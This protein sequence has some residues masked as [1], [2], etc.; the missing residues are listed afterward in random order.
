MIGIGRGIASIA[1]LLFGTAVF[2]QLN[3]Y[4]YVVVPTHFEDYKKSNQYQT[5]TV[6]KYLFSQE[7][8][9]VVYDTQ[10][11]KELRVEPCL[12]AYVR[13]FDTSGMFMTRV[14]L[15]LVDCEGNLILETE[16]G[17]SKSKD[18]AQAYKEALM[19]A[20][21]SIQGMEYQ[22]TPMAKTESIQN[23]EEIAPA[24]AQ[25]AVNEPIITSEGPEETQISEPIVSESDTFTPETKPALDYL[26]AQPTDN[27]YQLV[28]SVPS[29]RMLLIKTSKP[30]TFLA[31]INGQNAGTVFKSEGVWVREY[32]NGAELIQEVLNIKF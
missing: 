20:F 31:L 6:I 23:P 12:G 29:I 2:G 11:P 27:G 15:E 10:Q 18:Y 28:D 16:E 14:K 25:Q 30:D 3:P 7:N 9:P 17:N 5:S 32:L 1:L 19:G 4:K 8:I 24:V 21:N 22:Y 13:L 26:Y